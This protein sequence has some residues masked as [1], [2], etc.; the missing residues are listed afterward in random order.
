MT[1]ERTNSYDIDSHI[2]EF[3]DSWETHS[4]DIELIR[5]L[6]AGQGRLRI[7]E[8][9]CGTGR[10]LVPLARDGHELVGMDQSRCMLDRA[11]AKIAVLPEDIRSSVTL[12]RTDV[13]TAD[14]PGGFDL[15][16]LGGNCFY[17][18]GSPQEQEA[19]VAYAAAALKPGGFLYADNDH[20]ED[21]V[22]SAWLAAGPRKGIFPLGTCAD[23]TRLEAENETLSLDLDKRLWRT[24]RRITITSPDGVAR[25]VEYR[26]QKHPVRH[27]E[28]RD[29]LLKHGFAIE[30]EFGDREGHPYT[31][32]SPRAIFW[33]RKE[34]L[35]DTGL[36]KAR[37]A[38]T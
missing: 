22:P 37:G 23:G 3:Y 25:N 9:F 28:V 13:L 5:R 8:P 21:E 33:A 6:I 38:K 12:S 26:Q 34:K 19:C 36:R 2:A 24:R 20:M 14:W 30:Q 27:A 18:L 35:K 10:I 4:Q 15:V 1:A 7:L 29:W 32:D 16:L 31:Y 17:E 11:E